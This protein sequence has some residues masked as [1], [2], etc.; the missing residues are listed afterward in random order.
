MNWL[1]ERRKALGL[2]QE[3]LSTR[4]Q[5]A[6]FNVSRSTIS[7]LETGRDTLQIDDPEL[8][9][10][11]AKVLR[12]ST[13]TILEYTGYKL[14]LDKLSDDALRAVELIEHMSPARRQ[15]ALLLLEQLSAET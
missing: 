6:G 3:E 13:K 12:L 8:I 5:L 4:L 7:H 15:T 10:A 14:T 11:F 2:S 1:R 9:S